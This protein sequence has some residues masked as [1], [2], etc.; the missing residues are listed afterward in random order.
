MG[1]GSEL[2]P[3]DLAKLPRWDKTIWNAALAR[4]DHTPALLKVMIAQATGW[5]NYRSEYRAELALGLLNA[6]T[7][8]LTPAHLRDLCGGDGVES[9]QVAATLLTHPAA[10]GTVL[11]HLV[12]SVTGAHGQALH[13]EKEGV[14]RWL[15]AHDDRRISV[16]SRM[17][18]SS[19]KRWTTTP[20][21][22]ITLMAEI[23]DAH[24][25]LTH[26]VTALDTLGPGVWALVEQLWRGYTGR[27]PDFTATV[28]AALAPASR[29]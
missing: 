19:P 18:M 14:R 1:D 3:D 10:D 7:I 26:A 2:G 24:R 12:V 6:P 28:R 21:D 13:P 9:T 23:G 27:G 4:T 8:T 11:P 5:P 20:V 22:R 29:T 17:W 25:N 16:V 15:G